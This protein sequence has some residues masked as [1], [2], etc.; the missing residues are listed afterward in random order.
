[1]RTGGVDQSRI[2]KRKRS[3]KPRSKRG[4]QS[5]APA[6]SQ[7]KSS[8]VSP[9]MEVS[10]TVAS[11]E[12]QASTKTQGSI[13]LQTESTA[14]EAFEHVSCERL[15]TTPAAPEMGGVVDIEHSFQV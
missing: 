6:S 13:E 8:T 4:S 15:A 14:N 12:L 5:Q 10:E 9:V 2:S 7:D 3:P 11:N 1:M